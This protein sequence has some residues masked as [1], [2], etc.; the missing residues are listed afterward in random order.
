MSILD[1]HVTTPADEAPAYVS[2][3]TCGQPVAFVLDPCEHDLFFICCDWAQENWYELQFNTENHRVWVYSARAYKHQD[4]E[5]MTWEAVGLAPT[6]TS[7]PKQRE[8]V[9]A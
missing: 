4:P 3:G 5:K 1:D 7:T 6:E 9:P 8:T 2:R